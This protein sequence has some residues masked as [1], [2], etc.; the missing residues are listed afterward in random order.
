VALTGE[1]GG[2]RGVP[3]RSGENRERDGAKNRQEGRA[4]NVV[5]AVGDVFLAFSTSGK[6]VMIKR[7]SQFLTFVAYFLSHSMAITDGHA[8]WLMKDEPREPLVHRLLFP[9][10][11]LGSMVVAGPLVLLGMLGWLAPPV[12]EAPPPSSPREHGSVPVEGRAGA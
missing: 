9:F 2:G 11:V 7:S 6:R 5:V 10:T 3:E 4:A 12:S 8:I 1:R